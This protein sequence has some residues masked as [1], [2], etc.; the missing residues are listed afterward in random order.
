LFFSIPNVFPCR[1][2][3]EKCLSLLHVCLAFLKAFYRYI[4]SETF[5]TDDV[6]VPCGEWDHMSLVPEM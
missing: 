1:M 3:N 4:M 5:V 2:E 6:V